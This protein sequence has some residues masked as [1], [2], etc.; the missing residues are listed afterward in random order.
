MIKTL[1]LNIVL[2]LFLA[3]TAYS[4]DDA[5]PYIKFYENK[6]SC[7]LLAKVKF[8]AYRIIASWH[9]E[10]LTYTEN[11][12]DKFDAYREKSIVSLRK[13]PITNN[14]RE[15]FTDIV[16]VDL[17]ED[18]IYVWERTGD[19]SIDSQVNYTKLVYDTCMK[20]KIYKLHEQ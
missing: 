13:L 18:A 6:D 17:I 5:D 3:S 16:I 19:K 1:V 12:G 11:D 8:E 4:S 20:R 14:N 15:L 10:L 2:I 7:G 9:K